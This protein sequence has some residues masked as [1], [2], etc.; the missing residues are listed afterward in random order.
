MGPF[1][2]GAQ[3]GGAQFSSAQLSSHGRSQRGALTVSFVR[4]GKG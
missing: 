2:S 4:A 1:R 3:V